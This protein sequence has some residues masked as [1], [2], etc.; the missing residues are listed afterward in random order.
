MV[1]QAIGKIADSIPLTGDQSSKCE[2]HVDDVLIINCETEHFFYKTLEFFNE[3][4]TA[5]NFG[6]KFKL[7]VLSGLIEKIP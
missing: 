4:A 3:S 5:E 1:E 7:P 2:I 6:A